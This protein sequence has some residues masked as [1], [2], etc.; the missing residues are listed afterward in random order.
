LKWY[1][2]AF[3]CVTTALALAACAEDPVA[4]GGGNTTLAAPAIDAP[5]D[6]EQLNTLRPTIVVRNSTS[7]SSGSRTYEFQLATSDTFAS[8][9]LTRS[10]IPE[11]SGGRTSFTPDADLQSTTRYFWRARVSQGSSTSDWSP[12]GRFR[13]RVAGYNNAGELFDPLT[14]GETVGTVFGPTEWVA[15]K[16]LKLVSG[17]SFV[18]YEL[19][20]TISSGE[21]SMLIENL[22]PN[23]PAGKPRVF[24]MSDRT[25]LLTDSKFEM[26]AQYRGRPGNPDNCIAFKAIW[27]DDDVAL[28]PALHERQASI[29]IL[30]PARTYFWQ[31]IWNPLTFR[32]VVRE[33]GPTGNVIFDMSK[34]SPSGYGPYAPSPH[35]AYLGANE[36]QFG[37]EDGT[38]PGVT[39]R[40]V[41][42]SDR[43]RPASLGSAVSDR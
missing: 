22:A 33:D 5:T 28:E 37:G 2:S 25:G 43:S 26:N 6:D 1:T 36:L 17:S 18:R 31:A 40:N 21:F 42:L 14:N 38:S 11:G 29:R 10:S 13:T 12:I 30:D 24:S 39:I 35:Y 19:P 7:S 9:A 16:G 15:G 32:L 27:G 4:P 8:I 3:F 41:W 23:G 34:T 20:R